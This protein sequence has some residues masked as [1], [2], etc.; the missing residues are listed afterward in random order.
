MKHIFRILIILFCWI[1][2]LSA[3]AQKGKLYMESNKTYSKGNIYIKKSL[4]PILATKLSLVYDTVL[5]YT[6]RE[7]GVAKSLNVTASSINYVKIK[8]GTKAGTFALYGGLLMLSSSLYAVLSAEN[9]SVDLYGETSKINWFPIVGGCTAAG[10][11]I[12][13]LI[14]A[15]VPKYKNFYIKDNSTKYTFEISPLYYKNVG[16]VGIGMHVTF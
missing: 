8:T 14:G 15:L 1:I 10:V 12:G 4:I 5:Q 7:T 11:F 2:S 3:L 16:G 6:D 13:G 9:A